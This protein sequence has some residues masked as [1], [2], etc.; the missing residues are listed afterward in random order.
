M[1]MG[2]LRSLASSG[3]PAVLVNALTL[4]VAARPQD[5]A[6]GHYELQGDDV[7]M[8]VMQFATQGPEQKK[9]ELHAQYIDIQLLLAGEERILFGVAGSARE[10]EEMHSAEDYQLC[11]RIEEQ[12]SVVLKPGMFVVFMPGEPHK[13][14]CIVESVGEIKKVVVKVRAELL[15]A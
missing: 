9:A 12:Q 3:L 1:M 4:A 10:C 5:K 11:S 13:P 2:E 6:P 14:G 15:S 7:F 8:N